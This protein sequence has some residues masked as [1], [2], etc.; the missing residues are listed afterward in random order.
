MKSVFLFLFSFVAVAATGQSEITQDTLLARKYFEE[1]KLLVESLN[2]ADHSLLFGAYT[3]SSSTDE[4]SI[5]MHATRNQPGSNPNPPKFGE[6]NDNYELPPNP[7]AEEAYCKAKGS[8]TFT[9]CAREGIYF[10]DE[11]W[12]PGLQ[13]EHSEALKTQAEQIA[14]L[15]RTITELKTQLASVNQACF[16]SSS[17]GLDVPSPQ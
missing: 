1:A 10:N 4:G 7:P 8:E 16:T 12:V 11:A 15:E 2:E 5:V 17:N 9:V 13:T 3:K 14:T 6:N